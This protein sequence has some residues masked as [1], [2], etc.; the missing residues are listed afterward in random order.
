MMETSVWSSFLQAYKKIEWKTH[1][2]END[3]PTS[4]LRR[5]SQQIEYQ[6]YWKRFLRDFHL[7]FGK[8]FFYTRLRKKHPE[9]FP[10][11][12]HWDM[13]R[14]EACG[15]YPLGQPLS[16]TILGY[17]QEIS[18][19]LFPPGEQPPTPLPSLWKPIND[20]LKTT[21]TVLTQSP[22]QPT[23]LA[24]LANLSGDFFACYDLCV[25]VGQLWVHASSHKMGFL[26]SGQL[27]WWSEQ[28]YLLGLNIHSI[29][30]REGLLAITTPTQQTL[31]AL[32]QTWLSTMRELRLHLLIDMY[33]GIFADE[34]LVIRIMGEEIAIDDLF[35]IPPT[36]ISRLFDTLFPPKPLPRIATFKHI[37]HPPE[38]P[39]R[40]LQEVI[41]EVART[42]SPEDL[43]WSNV[44]FESREFIKLRQLLAEFLSMMVNDLSPRYNH[45]GELLESKHL[46]D[47]FDVPPLMRRLESKRFI[48]KGKI[49]GL[50]PLEMQEKDDLVIRSTHWVYDRIHD[51]L[52]RYTFSQA[53]VRG[54]TA[55]H[56]AEEVQGLLAP[57]PEEY[58]EMRKYGTLSQFRFN[59]RR[60]FSSPSLHMR[61]LSHI[62]QIEQS[63]SR[64]K[65]L[66]ASQEIQ[67][68]QQMK[69][70][71]S[72]DLP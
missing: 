12:L 60:I 67:L 6:F 47:Q 24:T 8:M 26:H 38:P 49:K 27:L 29:L 33:Q 7:P 34:R 65:D 44:I 64:I 10:P 18:P 54:E 66:I 69:K 46:F 55:R 14:L 42:P 61:Y 71:P 19:S 1:L 25:Y 16:T 51:I 3:W 11:L 43:D 72:R 40:Q 62:S 68:F 9:K 58:N 52:D 20:T 21:L 45:Q 2:L 23:W 35:P 53:G 63:L 50:S 41:E 5:V 48:L 56:F 22:R 70:D 13:L 59:V 37:P 28:S 39:A 57:S 36:W 30:T 31:Y 15:S 4:D 32:F 17:F